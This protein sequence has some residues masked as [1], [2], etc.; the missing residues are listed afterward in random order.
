MTRLL[1]VPCLLLSLAAASATVLEAQSLSKVVDGIERHYNSLSALQMGFEQSMEYGGQKRMA[2]S[3]TLYLQRPGKMRWEYSKPAGKIAISD[4]KI[5]RMYN[6]NSNQ[7][8]QVEMEAM[9]DLRAPL[10]FLLGRMRLRRMFRNLR[11]EQIDGRQVLIGDGRNAQD[12]YARVEFDFDPAGL[13]I[14]GIRIVGRDDS[15]NVYGFSDEQA[16]PK[17]SA[18]MFEFKAPPDA[19]VVPLTRTF[20]SLPPEAREQ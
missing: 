11:L 15:V 10:S 12:I 19:E 20:N 1:T 16:N 14:T 7:V 4:G 3:G 8:R 17:L 6:P 5:F 13:G 9:T 18:E 2:E